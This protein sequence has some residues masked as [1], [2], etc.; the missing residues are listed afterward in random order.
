[1]TAPLVD[2]DAVTIEGVDPDAEIGC[3]IP[4]CDAAAT[5]RVT[6]HGGINPDD[7]APC[8]TFP[9]FMCAAHYEQTVQHLA[10]DLAHGISF[11]GTCT[12]IHRCTCGKL[13]RHI[14][15][16]ILSVHP[17]GGGQ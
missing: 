11:L 9:F 17:L 16:V 3:E 6:W 8:R 2:V 14:S 10:A 4:D 5:L 12:P 15:D 13:L 7:M 1:M